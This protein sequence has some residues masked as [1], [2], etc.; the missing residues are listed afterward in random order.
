[1][2]VAVIVNN[3]LEE[4][5]DKAL[6]ADRG[7][8]DVNQ[9][10]LAELAGFESKES[11]ETYLA[12]QAQ[13]EQAKRERLKQ[14]AVD[15]GFD[16]IERMQKAEEMGF[17]SEATYAAFL[18]AEEQKRLAEAEREAAEAAVAAVAAADQAAKEQE[19]QDRSKRQASEID[20]TASAVEGPSNDEHV[21]QDEGSLNASL[22]KEETERLLEHFAASPLTFISSL[23]DKG[24]IAVILNEQR[25]CSAA[26]ELWRDTP[27]GDDFHSKLG[28][29]F[30]YTNPNDESG[31]LFNRNR[32]DCTDRGVCT[33]SANKD[34]P[35]RVKFNALGVPR[36]FTANWVAWRLDW[37]EFSSDHRV[38]RAFADND[39]E[40][41][42]YVCARE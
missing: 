19:S 26:V 32:R 15:R 16:S 18:A 38:V 8:D 17:T 31:T 28:E 10:R 6:A 20:P 1:M 35:A 27:S 37:Q 13:E 30:L 34:M 3:Q 5:A 2:V 21:A 41:E 36:A 24:D 11:Y 33:P 14:L 7:F 4:R 42:F 40:V 25:D 12:R 39:I 23:G 22:K 9:M 29:A